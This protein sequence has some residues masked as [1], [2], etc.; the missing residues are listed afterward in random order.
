MRVQ[1][2]HVYHLSPTAEQAATL[3]QWAGTCRY[4]YNLALEQRRDRWRFLR[5]FSS[6]Q[7]AAQLTALRCEA[8]WIEAVPVHALQYASRAVDALGIAMEMVH[9]S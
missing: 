2:A 5:K 7:Q 3:S 1:R 9:V 8:D 4:V 6:R